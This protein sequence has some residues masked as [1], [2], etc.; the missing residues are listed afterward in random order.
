M[1][2]HKLEDH[3]PGSWSIKQELIS[4]ITH[5]K[6]NRGVTQVVERLPSKVKALILTPVPPNK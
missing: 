3:G 1:G 5:T 2:K 4:K 6:S